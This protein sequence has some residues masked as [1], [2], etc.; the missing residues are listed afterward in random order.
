MD[1]ARSEVV[2]S[3]IFTVLLRT[4]HQRIVLGRYR[5]AGTY[6]SVLGLMVDVY[7]RSCD[8]RE[9]FEFILQSLAEVV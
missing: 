4:A 5:I 7:E 8:T 6:R 9:C 3:F 2:H 1:A